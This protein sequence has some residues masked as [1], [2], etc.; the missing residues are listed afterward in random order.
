MGMRSELTGSWKFRMEYDTAITSRRGA[1][2]GG[3]RDLVRVAKH[4][5]SFA[6][7]ALRVVDLCPMEIIKRQ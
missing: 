1:S 5:Q 3:V 7:G 4:G 2:A 6:E